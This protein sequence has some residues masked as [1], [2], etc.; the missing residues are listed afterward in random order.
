MQKAK[1]NA[2]S[3]ENAKKASAAKLGSG[4]VDTTKKI[5]NKAKGSNPEIQ[6]RKVEQDNTR[7]EKPI[8]I[9][10]KD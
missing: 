2:T 10:K 8:K 5:M 3:I 4:V 6:G 1:D 9:L 7:V